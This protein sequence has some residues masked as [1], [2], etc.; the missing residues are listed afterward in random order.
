MVRRV[1]I[2]NAG[3]WGELSA[4]KGSYDSIAES[5]LE[6]L[7]M[8][9]EKDWSGRERLAAEA[10]VMTS[11]KEALE[12]LDGRGTVIYL[13]RGMLHEARKAATEYP[14]LRIVLLT[15]D[16]PEGEVIIA[17]KQWVGGEVL[18]K[19]ALE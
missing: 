2:V 1:A 8:A 19:M 13:T 11:S 6:L 10:R 17:G 12:W 7:S 3:G 15:G 5:F 9:T 14:K 16:L 4:K 18:L